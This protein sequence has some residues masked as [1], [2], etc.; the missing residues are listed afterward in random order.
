VGRVSEGSTLC[1]TWQDL[2]WPLHASTYDSRG[3]PKWLM[4]TYLRWKSRAP[5][6]QGTPY[7]QL[8]HA[9]PYN[10]KY[11]SVTALIA[12]LLAQHLGEGGSVQQ[13][14]QGPIF[15]NF[16]PESGARE[17]RGLMKKATVSKTVPMGS[18]SNKCTVWYEGRQ[19]KLGKEEGSQVEDDYIY[20]G[21]VNFTEDALRKLVY[22]IYDV[23]ADTAS[24]HKNFGAEN[25]LRA[26]TCHTLRA[27]CVAWSARS[28]SPNAFVEAKLT[29]RWSETSKVSI[30]YTLYI[31]TLPH[32]YIHLHLRT[33]SVSLFVSV[34]LCQVFQT[35]WRT[36]AKINVVLYGSRD[37]P[38]HKFK[39]WPIG[40]TTIRGQ[41]DASDP[42]A[43]GVAQ[44][45]EGGPGTT[46]LR[47]TERNRW[48]LI[49]SSPGVWVPNPNEAEA[50]RRAA[51]VQRLGGTDSTARGGGGD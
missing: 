24:A 9:N 49:E 14:M 51:A 6:E 2:E 13:R 37:D 21:R 30:Y 39:P 43:R 50:R 3:M 44:L 46:R 45:A 19:L 5:S 10:P 28:K 34:S 11:C 32:I 18:G 7:P 40:G 8:L 20:E 41:N 1:P 42:V 22:Q 4:I 12:H 27:T 15:G 26:A 16:K 23:A 29:G 36:G 17:V 31:Y 47:G 48:R 35:Y 33:H 38:I 25:R